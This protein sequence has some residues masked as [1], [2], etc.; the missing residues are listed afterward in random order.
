VGWGKK[1]IKKL[2]PERKARE[3][4]AQKEIFFYYQ[5]N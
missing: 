4:N 2:S 3:K 1:V 5:V